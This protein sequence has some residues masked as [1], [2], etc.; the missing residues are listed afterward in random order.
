MTEDQGR[1]RPSRPSLPPAVRR[2]AA[3]SVLLFWAV[4]LTLLFA[5]SLELL[6]SVLLAV[7]LVGVPGL[8]VAQLPLISGTPVE[9]LPAYWSSIATLWLLGTAAWLVGTRA[10]GAAGL[11]LVPMPW[12][13]MA[14]WS[15]GL[16]LGGL[17]TIVAFQR[18]GLWSG[19]SERPMLHQLLPRTP[20]ERSTFGVL[21]VAAGF[22]EEF[23]YRGYAITVLVPVLGV[24][25]AVVLTSAVFGVLHGYQGA[26]GI[27][28]TGVMG[29]MLAWGF[30]SSGSLWPPIVAHTMIDL[31]AGLWL[32]E[33]LL[34]PERPPGVRDA[35]TPSF[36]N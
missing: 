19:I 28:R 6:D 13:G 5:A 29:A 35:D 31:V 8:S 24:P 33:R 20:K 32:G 23:A 12:A 14:L 10:D 16:T 27:F 17:L 7:L 30:L 11:G 1:I 26:L 22:G 21:S 15:G 34:S 18:I 9:R 25:G 4:L 36:E 2:I 3:A